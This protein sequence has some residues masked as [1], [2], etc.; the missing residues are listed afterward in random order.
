MNVQESAQLC[1]P[2]FE[3]ELFLLIM[4]I[5]CRCEQVFSFWYPASLL[6]WRLDSNWYV[7][8]QLSITH[9]WIRF[10][11]NLL[12]FLLA[13]SCKSFQVLGQGKISLS[14][15]NNYLAFTT[16]LII[17]IISSGCNSTFLGCLTKVVNS[18]LSLQ[19]QVSQRVGGFI[20]T[21]IL[22]VTFWIPSG[23][24]LA[25]PDGSEFAGDRRV[26]FCC[27]LSN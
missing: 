8:F 25:V 26:P 17:Y 12:I 24:L 23:H 6:V 2:P 16:A 5:T 10:T 27:H 9:G 13:K 1:D 18:L 15:K 14:W 20:H 11:V 19:F 21:L 3:S 4:A 22:V 7:L